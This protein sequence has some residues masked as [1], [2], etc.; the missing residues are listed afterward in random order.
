MA[1][2]PDLAPLTL[3]VLAPNRKMGLDTQ[4]A[5]AATDTNTDEKEATH[6]Q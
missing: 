3:A 1:M 4:T 5:L 2:L 6:G